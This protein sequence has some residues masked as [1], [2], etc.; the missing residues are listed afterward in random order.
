MIVLLQ[1]MSVLELN[2]DISE[3]FLM[4]DAQIRYFIEMERKKG[5][6][7][8]ELIFILSDNGISIYEISN[9]LDISV[10]HV[11]MVLSDG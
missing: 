10:K 5:T 4:N 6:T 1:L 2:I 3:V 8:D 9:Y 11:E 7:T